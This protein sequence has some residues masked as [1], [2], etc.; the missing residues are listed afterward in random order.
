MTNIYY[1]HEAEKLYIRNHPSDIQL[2]LLTGYNKRFYSSYD[3]YC[4]WKEKFPLVPFEYTLEYI[5]NKK[6]VKQNKINMFL[7]EHLK[8]KKKN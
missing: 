8:K 7:K 5:Q 2:Q 6:E 4:I 1:L 3:Y